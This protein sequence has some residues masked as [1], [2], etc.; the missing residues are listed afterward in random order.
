MADRTAWQAKV[1]D[2]I[3]VKAAKAAMSLTGHIPHRAKRRLFQEAQSNP[4]LLAAI[5]ARGVANL[6]NGTDGAVAESKITIPE[7]PE[8][9]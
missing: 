5:V 8:A 4:L 2:E 3:A 7:P 1:L 9:S 6:I